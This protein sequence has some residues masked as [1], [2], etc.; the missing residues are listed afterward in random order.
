[1]KISMNTN[2]KKPIV[3]VIVVSALLAALILFWN[4]GGNSAAGKAA[5]KPAA[6]KEEH[7]GEHKDEAEHVAM[8]DEQIKSAG[9]VMA[10]AGPARI[11]NTVQLPGEV[12]FNEDRTAHV[13][14]RVAGVAASVSVDLGQQVKKGQVLAVI[15]SPE[16]ADLRSAHLAAQ[17]RLGLAKLTYER[18]KK[19]WQ[20]KISAEQ[21][22]LQAQQ[23][24]REAE[25]QEQTASAKLIALGA[26]VGAGALNQY[27]LRAPFD[28][29][30]VEKHIAQGEA[31]KE[32][33]NVFL[34][35]NL[36]TVWVEV[37]VSAN[38]IET[39]RVG[40]PVDIKS[41]SSDTTASG[42]ISYVGSLLG[43]Q[44]RTAKARVIIDNPK[45]AWRPGQFLNVTLTRGSKDVAVAVPADA[46]Q[47]VEGKSVVFTKADKG[48]AATPVR[49]G[50]NDGKSVEI[51]E[52][53]KPG[54]SYVTTGSYVVK[55]EQGKGSAEHEH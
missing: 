48:F 37:V 16:L 55:A 26:D 8:S 13:V 43:E 47:E 46:I 36:S 10:T 30:V 17:K 21:D 24:Y 15:S 18:E 12:K 42:K 44:T 22:Y 40:A 25:I 3:G 39:V 51:L 7:G 50:L 31:V 23:L 34:I 20:D 1:M 49:A 4:K 6:E 11:G 33:A 14:P 52:G 35:S 28:G 9:I 2:A 53:L 38:D 19:L 45:M 32:D 29:I 41:S 27:T 5:E 54:A